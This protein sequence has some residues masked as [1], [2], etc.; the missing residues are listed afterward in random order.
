MENDREGQNENEMRQMSSNGDVKRPAYHTDA[1][2]EEK[3]SENEYRQIEL[4]NRLTS[5]W[6][7]LRK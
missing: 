1:G 7:F 6:F 2:E 3:R 5:S 4:T